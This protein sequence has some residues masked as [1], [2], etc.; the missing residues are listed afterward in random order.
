LAGRIDLLFG[1]K[2]NL[3][4]G[5]RLPIGTSARFFRFN[6]SVYTTVPIEFPKE[7]AIKKRYIIERKKLLLWLDALYYL[8]IDV[9]SDDIDM[10]LYEG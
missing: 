9:T 5:T 3:I 1:L 10:I 2:E 7:I 6:N 4:L 8:E